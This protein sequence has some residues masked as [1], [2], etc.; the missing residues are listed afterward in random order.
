MMNTGSDLAWT[1]FRTVRD[2]IWETGLDAQLGQ[3][4]YDYFEMA[5]GALGRHAISGEL[6]DTVAYLVAAYVSGA[7]IERQWHGKP[8]K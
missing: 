1:Y 8:A 5:D 2:R 7:V 3:Y 4:G 6:R